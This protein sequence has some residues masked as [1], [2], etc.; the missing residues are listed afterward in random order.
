MAKYR[1]VQIK[2]TDFWDSVAVTSP[3]YTI[4]SNSTYLS[5]IGRKYRL[6]F[7]YKGQQ[8]KASISLILSD[9]ERRC[10]LDELSIYNGILFYDNPEQKLTKSGLERFEATE[11]IIEELDKIYDS[12]EIALSP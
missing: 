3:Q 9:D 4:F 1:F 11:F 8:V 7:V 5:F 12:I 6:F 10:E 2:D